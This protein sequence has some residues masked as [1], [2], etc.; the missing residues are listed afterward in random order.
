MG[1]E[2]SRKKATE[3]KSGESSFAEIKDSGLPSGVM[4]PFGG[5]TAPSGY[6]NCDGSTKSRTTFANLF[7]AIG[8]AWGEGDGS[9]NFHLPDMRGRI[10]RGRDDGAGVDPD[11]GSRTASNSGGNTGDNVGSVQEDEVTSH[12]HL[13]TGILV[14]PGGSA[15]GG[16]ADFTGGSR[17]SDPTG[18]TETRMKN[19][20]V[21]YI[22]KT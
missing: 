3:A 15:T 4:L 18:G 20:N 6:L 19:A 8:T 13:V 17:T 12:T 5:P 16:G 11:A 10:P 9:T 22:I 2:L 1:V 14:T 21:N 7:T